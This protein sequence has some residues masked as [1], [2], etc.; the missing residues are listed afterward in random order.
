VNQNLWYDVTKDTDNWTARAYRGDPG[1][2]SDLVTL[3]HGDT[4]EDAR[5]LAQAIAEVTTGRREPLIWLNDGEEAGITDDGQFVL[6]RDFEG[7]P[8]LIRLEPQSTAK[9]K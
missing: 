9:S 3:A 6:I 2:T 4:S 8:A 1:D 5:Q 7:N